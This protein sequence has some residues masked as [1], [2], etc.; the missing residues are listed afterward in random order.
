MV[1]GRIKR[2]PQH[3]VHGSLFA[4][5][6]MFQF[7]GEHTHEPHF[8][9]SGVSLNRTQV[10][11]GLNAQHEDRDQSTLHLHNRAQTSMHKLTPHKL[12][13]LALALAHSSTQSGLYS[14]KIRLVLE[15]GRSCTY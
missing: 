4:H 12:T 11:S 9:E 8:P 7:Y 13:T 10:E 1:T 14:R 15:E 5:C 6:G 3:S 2:V